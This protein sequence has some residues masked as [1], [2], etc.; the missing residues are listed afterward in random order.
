MTDL[1]EVQKKKIVP[2]YCVIDTETTSLDSTTGQLLTLA[3]I[4]LDQHL[5]EIAACQ[6]SFV[7]DRYV[8][9]RKALETNQID[10]RNHKASYKEQIFQNS[11]FDDV[12]LDTLIHYGNAKFKYQSLKLAKT[13]KECNKQKLLVIGSNPEF[14]IGFLKAH[15]PEFFEVLEFRHPLDTAVVGHTWLFNQGKYWAPHQLR[16]ADLVRE[17]KIPHDK[18]R[19]HDAEYDAELAYL[20]YRTAVGK[21]VP[22]PK[23]TY[24]IGD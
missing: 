3:M 19:L 2:T 11:V 22:T 17:M 15:E 20:V 13:L 7:H 21:P 16:L 18:D 14:D 9:D 6:E 10:L 12:S 1:I 5:E 4:F 24:W 8:A 23:D